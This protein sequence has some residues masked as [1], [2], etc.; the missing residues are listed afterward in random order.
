[1]LGAMARKCKERRLLLRPVPV[2]SSGAPDPAL[3]ELGWPSPG[4]G[5]LDSDKPQ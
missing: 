5:T 3:P 4:L 1:M 2:E